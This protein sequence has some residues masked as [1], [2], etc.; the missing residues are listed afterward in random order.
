LEGEAETGPVVVEMNHLEILESTQ[1]GFPG[2]QTIGQ[3]ALQ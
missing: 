3:V 2:A 1:I